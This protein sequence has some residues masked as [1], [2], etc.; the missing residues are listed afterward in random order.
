M[1]NAHQLDLES[2]IACPNCDALYRIGKVEKGDHARCTRCH[3]FLFARRRD[4]GLIIIATAL[5]STTLVIAA[6]FLPFIEISRL[7]FSNAA[8][9]VDAALA[10]YGGPLFLL[11][12]T[13]LGLIIALPLTRLILTLYTLIPL[14]LDKPPWPG[15]KR[16]FRLSEALRPWSMAE[17]F[18]VGCTVSLIKL[19]DLARVELGPAFWMFVAVTLL[20]AV[21]SMVMCRWSVWKALDR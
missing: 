17:I 11:S 15:A 4:A 18:L 21:Q 5:A 20:M 7:G 19:T 3:T 16:A 13:V 9:I 6:L 2:L 14:V 12:L 10:F 8:T 1:Q